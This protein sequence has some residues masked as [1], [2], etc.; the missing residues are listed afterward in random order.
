MSLNSILLKKF[1]LSVLTFSE[2]SWDLGLRSICIWLLFH[3]K[4]CRLHRKSYREMGA[5]VARLMF[6]SVSGRS[7]WK[8]QLR[9]KWLTA[10]R[11]KVTGHEVMTFDLTPICPRRNRM[12]N[13]VTG[14]TRATAN[15]RLAGRLNK[16]AIIIQW[17]Q[18]ATTQPK[19][20]VGWCLSLI[21]E[22]G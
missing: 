2:R 5:I 19:A 7:Q 8:G 21:P 22:F 20:R 11:S 9:A 6:S 14:T 13:A 10:A 1:L 18:R 15:S 17:T 16:P 12:L 4:H 3:V